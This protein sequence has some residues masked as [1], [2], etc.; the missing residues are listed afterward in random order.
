VSSKNK[1][2]KSV[3]VC[4]CVLTEIR[5]AQETG[6]DHVDRSSCVASLKVVLL[7]NARR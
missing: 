5:Q 1:R 4:V 6:S 3:C 2:E 7:S